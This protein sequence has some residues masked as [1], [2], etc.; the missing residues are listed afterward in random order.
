MFLGDAL[1]RI[2]FHEKLKLVETRTKKL[3]PRTQREISI[4]EYYK[5]NI[6]RSSFFEFF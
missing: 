4:L 6:K 5:I 1:N 3:R 2:G